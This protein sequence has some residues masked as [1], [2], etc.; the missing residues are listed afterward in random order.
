MLKLRENAIELLNSHNY[1]DNV[2]I[3][4]TDGIAVYYDGG[5]SDRLFGDENITGRHIKE[6]YPDLDLEKSFIIQAITKGV[7]TYNIQEKIRIIGGKEIS[8]VITVLPILEDGRI[9]GAVEASMNTVYDPR[10]NIYIT[11]ETGRRNRALFHTDD[12]ISQCGLMCKVKEKIRKVAKTDSSVLIYGKTGTGKEMVA[13]SIH[14][15]GKRRNKPFMSQNCAAIPANLLESMLFGTVRGSFTGAEDKK[16]LLESADGGTVFLDEINNMDMALQ[17]KILKAI[18]EQKITRVGDFEPRNINVRIIAATNEDPIEL[19]KRYSLR[20]D[21]YYRLRVVQINLPALEE[22]KGDIPLLV[23]HFIEKYNREM[24]REITGIDD[25]MM[26]AILRRQWHGNIRELENTIECAFNFAEGSYL[27]LD[28]V[29]WLKKEGNKESNKDEGE[30]Y[31]P[32]DVEDGKTLKTMMQEYECYLIR[33]AAEDYG[34][35]RSVADALGITRQNLNHKIKQYQL[36]NKFY[37]D[38]KF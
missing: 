30:V 27:T 28:D 26:D 16:G 6:I 2:I 24:H 25:D 34:D 36:E 29:P 22:R 15:E 1:F 7:P 8:H 35:F 38:K 11:P 19:V 31:K 21:L 33:Q 13:E 23:E 18:E 17:A 9:T 5:S 3:F 10:R 4:D 20:E 12:I 37:M 14:T 32:F